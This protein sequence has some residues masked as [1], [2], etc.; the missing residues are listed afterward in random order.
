M[1][2]PIIR[3]TTIRRAT[4]ALGIALAALTLSATAQAG[5]GD[6]GHRDRDRAVH[7]P[8]DS[9]AQRQRNRGDRSARRE[10]RRDSHAR[11]R[12]QNRWRH[13]RRYGHYRH[14]SRPR[15]HAGFFPG[16]IVRPAPHYRGRPAYRPRP[17]PRY[18]RQSYSHGGNRQSCRVLKQAGYDRHG[19][20]VV[21]KRRV[22]NGPYGKRTVS[23]HTRV[24]Q[25][26]GREI[27]HHD[28]SGD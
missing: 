25:T 6:R 22:C 15:R 12:G 1:T 21:S 8:R 20:R 3:G 19:R 2:N 11:Y 24:S 14:H 16:Y 5:H 27:R 18:H 4:A 7:G 10:I 26:F 28:D 9:Q 13:G 23:K 17:R